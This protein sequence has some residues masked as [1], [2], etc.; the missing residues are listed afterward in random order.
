MATHYSILAWRIPWTEEP[1]GLQ[2]VGSLKSDITE[3][4]T[5]SLS[6]YLCRRA[7]SLQSCPV[8]LEPMDY[9][10]SSSSIHGI[11]PTQGLNSGF[12]HL[13]C[14]RQNLYHWATKVALHPTCY[15]PDLFMRW[16][17][18]AENHPCNCSWFFLGDT[19]SSGVPLTGSSFPHSPTPGP[20]PGPC[21]CPLLLFLSNS[22]SSINS[23]HFKPRAARA[24]VTFPCCTHLLAA[25]SLPC[26][27]F[28]I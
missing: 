27:S 4:L 25:R 14:H 11:L 13:L 17:A 12:L 21:T 23:S 9:S 24:H 6:A 19:A 7:Q 28:G 5:L 3:Q 26:F 18:K 16:A 15:R 8:L 22:F 10:P 1:G 20:V 2:S